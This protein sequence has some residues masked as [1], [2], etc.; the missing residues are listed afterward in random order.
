MTMKNI[1][2]KI[3]AVAFVLAP[4]LALAGHGGSADKIQAAVSSG[5]VDAIIAEVERTEFLVCDN[6]L[7]AMTSLTED[8]RLAVREVAAWWFARRPALKDMLASQ[9]VEELSVG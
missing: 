2:I 8:S 1:A 6:C 5:S 7:Q 3:A 4:Q 9:F